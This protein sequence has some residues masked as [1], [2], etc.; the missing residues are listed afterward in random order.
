M[1]MCVM[2]HCAKYRR[3][4]LILS[5]CCQTYSFL[6]V[7]TQKCT[8]SMCFYAAFRI[9]NISG[10]KQYARDKV[11]FVNKHVDVSAGSLI[12]MQSLSC[13]FYLVPDHTVCTNRCNPSLNNRQRYDL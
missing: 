7:I 3:T 8:C 5:G 11:V 13:H 2:L 4:K 6:P 10:K 1:P 12:S 9:I